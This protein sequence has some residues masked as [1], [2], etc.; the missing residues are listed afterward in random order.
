MTE[1]DMQEFVNT[2]RTDIRRYWR[3]NVKKY[4]SRREKQYM[5]PPKVNHRFMFAQQVDSAT[6]RLQNA[7][8][9]NWTPA[10]NHI[11]VT[12]APIMVKSVTIGNRVPRGTW[13]MDDKREQGK[14]TSRAYDLITLLGT[15]QRS[16]Y[17]SGRWV[18]KIIDARVKPGMRKSSDPRIWQDWFN[19][20][21]GQVD[22]KL[23]LFADGLADKTASYIVEEF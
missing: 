9:V 23:E 17:S 13:T 2:F 1:I 5:L 6:P 10:S 19:R 4:F 15:R 16:D 3:Q 7:L 21:T 11:T 8:V 20:F 18:A 12:T 22:K 14:M